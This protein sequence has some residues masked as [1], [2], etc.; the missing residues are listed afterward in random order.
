MTT[1]TATNYSIVNPGT[2][3]EEPVFG[4]IA[5]LT[6]PD[7]AYEA[8]L[9]IK[10]AFSLTTTVPKTSFNAAVYRAVELT[11]SR[12]KSGGFKFFDR[13]LKDNVTEI[14][15]EAL[16]TTGDQVK[17]DRE[18]ILRFV[19]T[20]GRVVVVPCNPAGTAWIEAGH[21]MNFNQ[22]V[23]DQK[24]LV[25]AGLVGVWADSCILHDFH[26]IGLECQGQSRESR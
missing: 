12:M 17:G 16:I 2:L 25:P 9:N 24:A 23:E 26:A 20:G 18:T 19:V 22:E 13:S 21:V 4:R 10:A 6:W 8:L 15:Q 3:A 14:V 5:T 1:A 11:A 7:M